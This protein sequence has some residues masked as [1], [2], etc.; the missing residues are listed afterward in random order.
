MK[1]R[2]PVG[3]DMAGIAPISL[4]CDTALLV[5]RLKHSWLENQII[6]KSVSDIVELRARDH[7]GNSN[8]NLFQACMKRPVLPIV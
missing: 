2:N 4:A 5:G 6:N 7:G 8:C 1:M 3:T